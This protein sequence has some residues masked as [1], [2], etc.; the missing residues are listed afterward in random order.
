MD[1][2][3]DRTVG[4]DGISYI[5]LSRFLSNLA[6]FF[7]IISL[8]LLLIFVVLLIRR[9]RLRKG[10]SYYVK[11]VGLVFLF[12][13]CATVISVFLSTVCDTYGWARDR[14]QFKGWLRDFAQSNSEPEYLFGEYSKYRFFLDSGAS[15]DLLRVLLEELDASVVRAAVDEYL[16]I[17][18]PAISEGYIY[19]VIRSMITD[20]N[21]INASISLY[22]EFKD[23]FSNYS[24]YND[25]NEV[26]QGVDISVEVN[27][28][29]I[30]SMM[31]GN[32][33]MRRAIIVC[34]YRRLPEYDNSNQRSIQEYYSL[35]LSRMGQLPDSLFPSS[36]DEVRYIIYIENTYDHKA[37]YS[38]FGLVG[39]YQH[40]VSVKVLSAVDSELLYDCGVASGPELPENITVPSGQQIYSTA[41]VDDAVIDEMIQAAIDFITEQVRG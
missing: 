39:G 14:T 4:S 34:F 36:L 21:D 30:S 37:T 1:S 31:T 19:N 16:N 29:Q 18:N 23:A 32:N 9:K 20:T 17:E 15:A 6:I 38:G 3:F 11:R 27:D 41:R 13:A 40:S 2:M 35:L 12:T 33:D 22:G 10:F 24:Y 5:P 7:I 8:A 28:R 25:Y 26:T